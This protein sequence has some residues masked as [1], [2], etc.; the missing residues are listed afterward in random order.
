M[1]VGRNVATSHDDH[2]LDPAADHDM[3]GLGEIA[4]IAGVI[5]TLV[6]LSRDETG[7]RHIAQRHRFA[8]HL[9]DADTPRGQDVAVLVNDAR[10]QPLQQTAKR[11]Q[12]PGVALGRRDSAVQYGKQ[13]G[14]DL[15]DHEAGAAFGKRHRHGR[16]GHAVSRQDRLRT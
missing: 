12:P 8:T 14:V 1:S 10:L 4:E 13:V 6:V 11:G 16:F 3:A 2:V 9:D 5:P 7:H 15:I